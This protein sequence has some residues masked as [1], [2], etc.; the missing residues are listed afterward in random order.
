M[1]AKIA[2]Y[3]VVMLV[4]SVAACF[5]FIGI[6][7]I[8][9]YASES[10]PYSTLLGQS[11]KISHPKDE[12]T[13]KILCMG[14]S[15]Y[16]YPPS[17]LSESVPSPNDLPKMIASSIKKRTKQQGIMVSQWAYPSAI[18]FDYYCLYYRAMEFS[19]DLIIVPINWRTFAADCIDDPLWFHPELSGLAPI[20]ANLPPGSRN[21]IRDRDISALRQFQYKLSFG[22]VY[23]LGVKRWTLAELKT[24][25]LLLSRNL[26]SGGF[27]QAK[28]S[29]IGAG[30]FAIVPE[31]MGVRF[32]A[33]IADDNPRIVSLRAL[34][35]VASKNQ[36]KI[37]FFVW[38]V[39]HER[40]SK[41]D[42]MDESVLEQSLVMI[43][44]IA[45]KKNTYFLDLSHLLRHGYFHDH[46][47][48]CKIQGREK[49]AEALAP[50][51][52][53]I[54]ELDELQEDIK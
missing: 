40:F 52:M 15:N 46:L 37:L 47:G 50:S 25:S 2:I 51:I 29:L 34:A 44:K 16:F 6:E 26:I 35:S 41:I 49:I 21:P 18:M 4:S 32:P 30:N 43:G 48:H 13:I 5:Q 33:R 1:P 7:K 3:Y 53:E 45:E 10:R 8:L 19:P 9:E 12:D 42:I 24:L 17:F 20:C 27:G 23:L 22:S 38:P 11:P 31:K 54:L 36:T 39:D 28:N 14:D